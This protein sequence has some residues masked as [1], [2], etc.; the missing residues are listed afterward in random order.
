MVSRLIHT[1]E[2]SSQDTVNPGL[3]DIV[4]PKNGM[5]GDP[6]WEAESICI[7]SCATCEQ[8]LKLAYSCV[9]NL[10]G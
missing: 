1:T 8:F 5:F 7:K 10:I 2:C 6:K 9:H 4:V 3:F